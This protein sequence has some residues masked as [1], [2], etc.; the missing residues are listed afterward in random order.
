MHSTKKHSSIIVAFTNI[1]IVCIAQILYWTQLEELINMKVFQFLIFPLIF[2]L[3]N[4]CLWFSR[5]RLAFYKHALFAYLA[6]FISFIVSSFLILI[7]LEHQE[8]PPREIVLFADVLF[9]CITA[10]V[11]VIILLF[12]N[13]VT[14]IFYEILPIYSRKTKTSN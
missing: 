10:T 3:V 2:I 1:V 7:V 5:Y 4:I 9:V 14:Y 6:F 12:L 13:A 11:Q 8:L